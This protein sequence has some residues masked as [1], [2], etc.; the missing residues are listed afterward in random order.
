MLDTEELVT[1]RITCAQQSEALEGLLQ[2]Q[3]AS[4]PH[5]SKKPHREAIG[6]GVLVTVGVGSQGVVA[7]LTLVRWVL[8]HLP[9][10]YFCYL[11]VSVFRES[12]LGRRSWPN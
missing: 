2:A 8:V 6:R 5:V 4:L 3:L 11:Q 12:G 7:V 9:I 10:P 1:V